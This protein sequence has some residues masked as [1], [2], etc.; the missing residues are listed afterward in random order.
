MNLDVLDGGVMKPKGTAENASLDVL[1]MI[2]DTYVKSVS[3]MA[4][5]PLKG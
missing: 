3:L 1:L 5:T 4:I 2:N